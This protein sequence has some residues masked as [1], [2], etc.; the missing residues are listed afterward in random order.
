MN[1][2]K[3]R[4][5]EVK[6]ANFMARLMGMTKGRIIIAKNK[7]L[8]GTTKAVLVQHRYEIRQGTVR[9]GVL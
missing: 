4:L 5:D 8:P 2:D 6:E 9:L 1:R 7:Y 3:Y